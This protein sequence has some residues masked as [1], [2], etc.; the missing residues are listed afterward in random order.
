MHSRGAHLA[1][2]ILLQQP[3]LLLLREGD[4]ARIILALQERFQLGSLF[5]RNRRV[6]QSMHACN[7]V[8]RVP[9]MLH[10]PVPQGHSPGKQAAL[11]LDSGCGSKP[12]LTCCI[13]L[14]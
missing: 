10:M 12:K 4:G 11:P 2:G 5:V 6:L 3:R 7:G 1:G 9:P 13:V 8:V 14:P